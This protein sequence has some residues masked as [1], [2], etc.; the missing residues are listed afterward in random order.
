MPYFHEEFAA[1]LAQPVSYASGVPPYVEPNP[2]AIPGPIIST[3][4]R[5]GDLNMALIAARRGFSNGY[6]ISTTPTDVL[7]KAFT[8]WLRRDRQMPRRIAQSMIEHAAADAVSGPTGRERGVPHVLAR[9]D[10]L[11]ESLPQ[12]HPT[13]A[14][15]NV[16][17]AIRRA[18]I[19]KADDLVEFGGKGFVSLS[20]RD[21][22]IVAGIAAD[23]GLRSSALD[24]IELSTNGVAAESP[25]HGYRRLA[26]ALR[27]R[28]VAIGD[29]YVRGELFD[30][31]EDHF[32]VILVDALSRHIARP[33]AAVLRQAIT[34]RSAA[35]P[36]YSEATHHDRSAT[37]DKVVRVAHLDLTGSLPT[38]RASRSTGLGVLI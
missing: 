36:D 18:A 34:G 13:P 10:G 32:G 30:L 15:A 22:M 16:I 21:E 7:N 17:S 28:S 12:N 14:V 6:P 31:L 19:A 25:D 8:T 1:L 2:A 26:A 5:D 27:S 33:S 20:D 4:E 37:C 9:L 29:P 23:A 11:V 3:I 35:M 38:G 24:A